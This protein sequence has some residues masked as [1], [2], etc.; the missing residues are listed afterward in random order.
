MVSFNRQLEA[1]VQR[2]GCALR[3]L[4]LVTLSTL[5]LSGCTTAMLGAQAL[6]Q[7]VNVALT[8]TNCR[9]VPP[10]VRPAPI[11]INSI[12]LSSYVDHDAE[13]DN[14]LLPLNVLGGA[15]YEYGWTNTFAMISGQLR[16]GLAFVEVE[17]PK[18]SGGRAMKQ[19]IAMG[20]E[21]HVSYLRFEFAAEGAPACNAFAAEVKAMGSPMFQRILLESV[22][23]GQCVASHAESEATSDY[24]LRVVDLPDDRLRKP[25]KSEPPAIWEIVD[26]R[27][28]EVYAHMTR[29][30]AVY[31][32]SCPKIDI[33]R[34]FWTLVEAK[35][36]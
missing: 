13:R 21:P 24:A 23:K 28:S 12:L 35:P 7:T 25:E 17:A 11:K 15:E 5:L 9:T 20:G 26:R 14:F 30:M 27:T 34:Q 4:Y 36:N 1:D 2:A 16:R 19:F 22:P 8:D 29:H 3:A 33:R 31:G 18:R 10:F 6:G 32:G